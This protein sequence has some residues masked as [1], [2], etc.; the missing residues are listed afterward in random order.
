MVVDCSEFGSAFKDRRCRPSETSRQQ[1]EHRRHRTRRTKSTTT[2]TT[3]TTATAAAATSIASAIE[4][5]T[6]GAVARRSTSV[7]A[8][9][10]GNR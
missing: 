8:A 1:R 3:A 10:R 2:A 7:V 4:C 5:A 9:Q 6:A